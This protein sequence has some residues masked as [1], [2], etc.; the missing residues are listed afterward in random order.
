MKY[1]SANRGQLALLRNRDTIEL[2][3]GTTTRTFRVYSDQFHIENNW[4]R[5]VLQY[6][7]GSSYDDLIRTLKLQDLNKGPCF[8]SYEEATSIAH[9]LFD[10]CPKSAPAPNLTDVIKI[11]SIPDESVLV[12][13][14]TDVLYDIYRQTCGEWQ[15]KLRGMLPNHNFSASINLSPGDGTH[16]ESG[17]YCNIV[18]A[19][20]GANT[21]YLIRNSQVQSTRTVKNLQ[22]IK[23]WE[24]NLDLPECGPTVTIS[25]KPSFVKNGYK[26]AN[27]NVKILVQKHI[28][29][30]YDLI[31]YA[32]GDKIG[33]FTII[34]AGENLVGLL[35]GAMLVTT[36]KQDPK[37]KMSIKIFGDLE[38]L[39]KP[40]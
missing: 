30:K 15:R 40:R 23:G 33:K 25:L 34:E 20:D 27:A 18:D 31:Q 21:V 10:L 4:S 39:A 5:R 24:I 2:T 22:N 29:E 1:T 17:V 37:Q 35:L 8:K 6:L 19:N 9:R 32:V 12:T 3:N 13:I 28:I 16:I 14:G 11:K 38:A 7:F 26:L 36:V